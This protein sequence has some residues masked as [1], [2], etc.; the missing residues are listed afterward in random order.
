M[1]YES[2]YKICTCIFLLVGTCL[3]ICPQYGTNV[4]RRDYEEDVKNIRSSFAAKYSIEDYD[5]DDNSTNFLRKLDNVQSSSFLLYFTG[6]GSCDSNGQVYILLGDKPEQKVKLYEIVS[7]LQGKCPCTLLFEL[8][9]RT[10]DDIASPILRLPTCNNIVVAI[11]SLTQE[12]KRNNDGG[13]WTKNLC[14][15]VKEYD[16]RIP[17]T[18]ILDLVWHKCSSKPYNFFPQYTA[19]CYKPS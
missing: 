11:S 17:M 2:H 12:E 5:I 6:Y 7:T 14:D 10:R 3:L 13:I 9:C 1:A 8:S 18:T 15:T 4:N 19:S 16:N